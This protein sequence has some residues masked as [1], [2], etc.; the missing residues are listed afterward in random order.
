MCQDLLHCDEA[1]LCEYLRELRYKL[2]M[3]SR[4]P[5]NRG[6]V[7]FILV[8]TCYILLLLQKRVRC[9]KLC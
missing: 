2:E 8:W 1:M 7:L 9:A 4:H 3:M 6:G 5:Y